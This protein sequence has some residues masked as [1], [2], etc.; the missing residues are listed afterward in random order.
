MTAE[1]TAGLISLVYTSTASQ[2]FRETALEEL[3]SVCR[4]RNAERDITGMLLYRDGRFIQVLEGDEHTVTRLVEAIGRDA[5]H[6]DLRVLMTERIAQ[7]RFGDWTMGYRAFRSG[8]DASPDG[9][10]DSFGDLDAGSDVSTTHRALAELTL[11]FRVRASSSA[12]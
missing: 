6:H 7:R 5:R 12:A 4:A 2:P 8:S 11:W 9:Y 1:Q 10:R 3:L